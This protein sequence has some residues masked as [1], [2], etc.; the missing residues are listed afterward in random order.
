MNADARGKKEIFQ[1]AE[2]NPRIFN[3]KQIPGESA[4]A[5][6]I[7]LHDSK[8]TRATSLKGVSGLVLS[9]SPFGILIIIL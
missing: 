5:A 8:V 6:V 9:S 1:K 7:G 2:R 4:S 3:V